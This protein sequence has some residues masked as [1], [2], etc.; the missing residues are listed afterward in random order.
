VNDPGALTQG[1]LLLGVGGEELR[2]VAV[3]VL[4]FDLAAAVAQCV[5]Q[6]FGEA[7]CTFPGYAGEGFSACS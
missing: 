5:G 3:K 4:D 6:E 2:Q 1:G 7:A